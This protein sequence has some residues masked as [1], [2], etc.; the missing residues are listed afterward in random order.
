MFQVE[1][2]Q[3]P[4]VVKVVNLDNLDIYLQRS[5]AIK[6][7]TVVKCQK[8]PQIICYFKDVFSNSLV[9]WP[10]MSKSANSCF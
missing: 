7:P 4:T 6:P 10:K 2:Y 5:L 9:R 1:Y 8:R 3:S